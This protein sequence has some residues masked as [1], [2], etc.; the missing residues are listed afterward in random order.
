[1]P[2]IAVAQEEDGMGGEAERLR[3]LDGLRILVLEGS[4]NEM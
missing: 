1:M 3:V 4:G 2:R